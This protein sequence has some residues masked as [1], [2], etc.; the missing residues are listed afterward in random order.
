LNQSLRSSQLAGPTLLSSAHSAQLQEDL[1][2][3]TQDLERSQT[4]ALASERAKRQLES[5]LDDAN[6]KYSS[7][8]TSKMSLEN[9]RL[10]LELQVSV[11]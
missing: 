9:A 8:L 5:Q 10:D 3:A 2:E 11:M 7:A 1:R 6:K 4:E